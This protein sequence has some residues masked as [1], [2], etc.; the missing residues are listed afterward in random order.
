MSLHAWLLPVAALLSAPALAEDPGQSAARDA[1]GGRTTYSV[2]VDGEV[3]TEPWWSTLGD[4][5]LSVLI[6]RA[7][8]HNP[9]VAAR[10]A[11]AD[12]SKMT[13]VASF[14]G[15]LPSISFDATASGSP[16]DALGFQFGGFGGPTSVDVLAGMQTLEDVTG[17]G[18]P[19]IALD[20]AYVTVEVPQEEVADVTWN[21]SALFNAR[22]ALDVF[23]NQTQSWKA[24]RHSA[25][26]AE[27]DADAT[28]LAVSTNVA[29]AWY[30]VVTAESRRTLVSEQVEVNEQLLELV[31][32]R[33]ESG[34]A[35]GLELLQQ[36]QQLAATQALLPAAELGVDRAVLRLGS[37]LGA[38]P[39]ELVGNLEGARVFPAVPDTAPIGSPVDLLR[40]RP[41]VVAA[42]ARIDSAH[43]SAQSA[44]RDALPTV[45]VSA[46]AG[47]QY[48][49]QGELA[50]TDIWGVGASV[51]VPLFNGG[52]V[53]GQS[54]AAQA[55]ERAQVETAHRAVLT[56]VQ[57]VEDA[58]L[59]DRQ[60][61]AELA[62][63][64]MQSTAAR[65]AFEDARDRYVRGLID[66]TTVLTTLTAWQNAEL[67]LISAKRSR[68]GARIALHDALGGPWTR[69]LADRGQP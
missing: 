68:I 66:L 32:L 23:G 38:N 44:W 17:D 65:Q 37:L 59:A 30:D 43:A 34:S 45:A 52:R 41:D 8:H 21:G 25:R 33:Y 16:T 36:R 46:N 69:T 27:G 61:H 20:P 24:S 60:S 19:D 1:L 47:W 56:A 35:T 54:K 4:P 39:S 57:E 29:I 63:I 7:L 26:A 13:S 58:V 50:S 40:N 42:V 18:I 9:D 62:A 53:Y 51:S 11:A 2:E 3:A 12:Q 67:S 15:L 28:A 48:F 55:A 14:S 5:A 49:S 6:L 31:T 10:S 22:W 64:T